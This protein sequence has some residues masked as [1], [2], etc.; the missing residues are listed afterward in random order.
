MVGA[1]KLLR[2]VLIAAMLSTLV[3]ACSGRTLEK[4]GP[5]I[6][7]T[8]PAAGPVVANAVPGYS[9]PQDAVSG[10]IDAYADGNAVLACSYVAPD[11]LCP[12]ILTLSTDALPPIKIG[13]DVVDGAEALVV[14]EGK[15]CDVNNRC[16]SYSN[17]RRGLPSHTADFAKVFQAAGMAIEEGVAQPVFPCVFERSKWRVD[18]P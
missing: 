6:T 5:P 7:A 2:M 4:A 14:V 17:P 3:A 15:L 9:T 1:V 16:K 12:T 18:L 11:P 10:F 8:S 13:D